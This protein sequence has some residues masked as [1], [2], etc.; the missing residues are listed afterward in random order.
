MSSPIC[1]NSLSLLRDRL[2]HAVARARHD[3]GSL[4]LLHIDLDHFKQVN[5]GFGRVAGDALLQQA[6]ARLLE[7]GHKKRIRWPEWAAM[8][9]SICWK[10]W[11]KWIEALTWRERFC[12]L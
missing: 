8:S 7:C 4:A 3:N 6:A 1:L 9:S 11:A 2:G 10:T 5:E 12:R